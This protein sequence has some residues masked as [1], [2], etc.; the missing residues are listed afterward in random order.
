MRVALQGHGES[1]PQPKIGNLEQAFLFVN[2]EILRFQ[3]PKKDE[4]GV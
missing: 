2:Q 3:V 4:Q 1:S